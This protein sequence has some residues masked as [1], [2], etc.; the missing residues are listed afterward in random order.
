VRVEEEKNAEEEKEEAEEEPL[1]T[2]IAI[3]SYTEEQEREYEEKM[4]RI[5]QK[6]ADPKMKWKQIEQA[7]GAPKAT[8][9]YTSSNHDDYG[10]ED[11]GVAVHKNSYEQ[12]L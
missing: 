2:P 10:Q 9:A 5:R 7:L 8:K 3:D 4:Q 11:N 6:K 12:I 1:T